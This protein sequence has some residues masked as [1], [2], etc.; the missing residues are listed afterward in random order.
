M[1]Q[2]VTMFVLSMLLTVATFAQ[3]NKT[4]IVGTWTGVAV[5]DSAIQSKLM[6]TLDTATTDATKLAIA[7]IGLS[8]ELLKERVIGSTLVFDK[9]GGFKGKSTTMSGDDLDEKGGYKFLKPDIIEVTTEGENGNTSTYK[10][11]EL[12]D[13]KMILELLDVT[14]IMTYEKR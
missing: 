12:N 13:R 10:V 3:N 11:L 8:A 6:Q 5:S 14:L 9:K 4:A 7:M 1:K 2:R